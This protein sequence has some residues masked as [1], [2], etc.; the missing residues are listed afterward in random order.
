MLVY[1]ALYI[2]YMNNLNN[3]LSNI[4]PK[5]LS[6]LNHLAQKRDSQKGLMIR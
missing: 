6:F 4:Y 2:N 1:I 5:K 3:V